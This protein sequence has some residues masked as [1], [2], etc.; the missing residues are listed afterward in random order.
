MTNLPNRAVPDAE[1]NRRRARQKA[2]RRAREANRR[3]ALQQRQERR[4]R[5]ALLADGAVADTHLAQWT[6]ALASAQRLNKPDSAP[7]EL[8]LAPN[9]LMAKDAHA[10]MPPR[11]LQGHGLVGSV[12]GDDR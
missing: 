1:S 3:L 12:V 8:G 11:T 6:Q 7:P 5:L 4:E 2:R 10:G 9:P